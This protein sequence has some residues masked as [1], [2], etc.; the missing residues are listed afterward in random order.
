MSLLLLLFHRSVWSMICFFLSAK[1]RRNR[2]LSTDI[3][4][5]EEYI[6]TEEWTCVKIIKETKIAA[7]EDERIDVDDNAT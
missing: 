2:S 3:K 5:Q 7:D 4:Q 1:R 6:Q